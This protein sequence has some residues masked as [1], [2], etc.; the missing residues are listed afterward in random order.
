MK[1]DLLL[2]GID[3]LRTKAVT[4]DER[5]ALDFMEKAAY[6]DAEAVFTD[7]NKQDYTLDTKCNPCVA[8]STVRKILLN[9]LKE[10]FDLEG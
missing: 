5:V 1:K 2:R 8:I 7:L 3:S 4:D 9:R 10:L 6:W